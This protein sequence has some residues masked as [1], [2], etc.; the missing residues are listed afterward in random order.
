MNVIW[1]STQETPNKPVLYYCHLLIVLYL[2]HVSSLG[3]F[4][5]T[6]PLLNCILIWIYIS[7]FT[8][9]NFINSSCDMFLN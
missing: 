5:G 2:V 6:Y 3:T 9:I 8:D 1:S 7:N 4:I